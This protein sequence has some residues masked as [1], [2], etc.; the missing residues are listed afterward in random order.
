[1]LPVVSC[2]TRAV[3]TLGQLS[4]FSQFFILCWKFDEDLPSRFSIK[5]G[6]LYVD[7]LNLLAR[8]LAQLPTNVLGNR[9]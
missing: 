3:H 8:L 2:I 4:T 1:M 9:H 6:A 7:D 5:I